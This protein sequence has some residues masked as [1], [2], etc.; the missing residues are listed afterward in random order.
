MESRAIVW[1]S[2]QR[3]VGQLGGAELPHGRGNVHELNSV[4]TTTPRKTGCARGTT[5]SG[6]DRKG[7]IPRGGSVIAKT[8]RAVRKG[9]EVMVCYNQWDSDSE[10]Y[11][12]YGIHPQPAT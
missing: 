4:F 7:L 5:T 10:L 9:T 6:H 12:K 8:E 1:T 2:R 11:A 3:R